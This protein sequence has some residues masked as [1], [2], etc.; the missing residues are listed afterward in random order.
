MK[1]LFCLY[2]VNCLY[3]F[4]TWYFDINNG[5]Y[6]TL[7]PIDLD[8]Y[9]IW[10]KDYVD[11]CERLRLFWDMKYTDQGISF[12]G[13]D[14]TRQGLWKETASVELTSHHRNMKEILV[15]RQM[16]GAWLVLAVQVKTREVRNKIHLNNHHENSNRAER[17]FRHLTCEEG[18]TNWKILRHLEILE[19]EG[20]SE[21]RE[22]SSCI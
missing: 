17:D 6:K 1:S 12:L 2:Q 9:K 14:S 20:E 15:I 11:I 10:G 19:N 3:Y 22:A 7:W 4:F 5:L 21:N 16:Y 18:I 8:G 13:V